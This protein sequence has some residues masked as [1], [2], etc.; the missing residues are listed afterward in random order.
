[1]RYLIIDKRQRIT[2]K[3][4]TSSK[5]LIQELEKKDYSYDFAYN[6]E[7]EFILKD[8]DLTIKAGGKDITEYSHIIFRGHSLSD[9]K[10]YHFKRYIIEYIDLYN[11]KN[12][13]KRILVQ[14]A[15]AIKNL[16]YYNKIATAIFCLKNNLPYF[17]T[18]FRTDG[19]YLQDRDILNDYPLIMKD[20]TGE[21]RVENIEG[22]DK[23]KKNVFKIDSEDDYKNLDNIDTSNMFLQEFSPSG[24][25]YR[26]FVKLGKVIGGWKRKAKG[27]F[28]TISKGEYEM[29]NNP[30]PEMR[31]IAERFATLIDADFMAVDFMYIDNKPY[32]QEISFH[33]GFKAYETKIIEGTPTNIAEAIITAFRE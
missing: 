15:Q 28:M 19:D 2:G 6:D 21:N 26:V 13:E 16:P 14:N 33:P 11:S 32:I 7:L 30:N 23:I 31:D 20:C 29:Y 5:R 3:I 12:P 9:E 8:G 1:M 25:D 10:G 17:D 27:S 24:E 4:S 22:K 18:Y